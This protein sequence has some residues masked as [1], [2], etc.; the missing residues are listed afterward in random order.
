MT[1]AHSTICAF[2]DVEHECATHTVDPD[3]KL[4]EAPRD[5]DPSICFACGA[6]NI[7]DDRAPG[8]M[9]KPT[10]REQREFDIDPE[11]QAA[12]DAWKAVTEV[13]H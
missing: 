4:R 1:I 9:R 13:R 10:K 2:C 8:G 7:F 3:G 11:V 6:I 12:C 5:G